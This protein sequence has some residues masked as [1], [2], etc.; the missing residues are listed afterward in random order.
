MIYRV[1]LLLISVLVIVVCGCSKPAVDE[2]GVPAQSAAVPAAASPNV[3]L[4]VVDTLRADRI[5]AARN[6]VPVMPKISAW[7]KESWN[8]QYCV[9]P[10]TWTKPS[11]VSMFTSLYPEVHRVL[12]GVHDTIVADQ[13]AESDA[14]PD[15]LMTLA[16]YLK[17]SG[18][19]TAAI[20][21]NPNLGENFGFHQGFDTYFFSPYP[22]F[23]GD[24][25]TK[26]ALVTLDE[27]KPPFFFYVHYMDPHAPYN[28]PEPH[29]TAFGPEP[30]LPESDQ[31]LLGQNY[32]NFYNDLSTSRSGGCRLT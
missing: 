9:T 25:V 11:M 21:T 20:Q 28:P 1:R 27:L 10:S 6:G 30:A 5:D 15:S 12:F 24:K 14:I 3:L 32:P 31:N 2:S 8:Y 4:I 29:R 17:S 26:K 23:T 19:Q 16:T 13:P 22:A 18:Y 7:A